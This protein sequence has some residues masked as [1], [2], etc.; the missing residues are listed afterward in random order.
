MKAID[1]FVVFDQ[2][3]ILLLHQP[4]D[5]D[6][7]PLT[8]SVHESFSMSISH[9][10]TTGLSLSPLRSFFFQASLSFCWVCHSNDLLAFVMALRTI[11]LSLGLLQDFFN[12]N[13]HSWRR[14][15][16]H[17]CGFHELYLYLDDPVSSLRPSE[18]LMLVPSF[19]SIYSNS[20]S[21]EHTSFR[22]SA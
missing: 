12:N 16:T 11:T 14:E 3:N 21:F 13:I 15:P 1:Q 20:A 18:R 8:I 9:L 7:D 17:T 2:N 19:L 6:I 4:E 22:F 5:I 10:T